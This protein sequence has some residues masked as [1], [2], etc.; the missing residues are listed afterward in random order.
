MAF[1]PFSLRSH[2]MPQLILNTHETQSSILGKHQSRLTN[3]RRLISQGRNGRDRM[4][5]APAFGI[6]SGA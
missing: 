4:T 3:D 2:V 1:S 5:F 6:D